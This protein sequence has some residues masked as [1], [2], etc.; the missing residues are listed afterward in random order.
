MM[1]APPIEARGLD[2]SFGAIPVLR[3]VNL[4]V[5]AGRGVMIIGRNGA[6]KSTLVRILAGLSTSTAG[7]A[8]LFGR[9]SRDLDPAQR[10]RVGLLTHQSF[11]YPNLTARENLEFYAK[12]YGLDG[13]PG[14][15]SSEIPRWL[16]RVGLAA[17]TNERVRTFSRGMEQRLVLARAML[18]APDVLLMDE[19]FAALDTDGVVLAA[20][21]IREALERG[22]AIALTAHEPLKLEVIALDLVEIVRGR[23]VNYQA[24][25]IPSPILRHGVGQARG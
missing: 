9:A 6:G 7:E 11:L 16:E 14:G 19:P 18:H 21:L 10:R 1:D 25:A 13:S 2:K 3:G 24:D 8:L 20:T 5:A 12:I 15:A 17:A 4:A 22:C 23:L